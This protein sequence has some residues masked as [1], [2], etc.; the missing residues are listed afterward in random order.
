MKKITKIIIGATLLFLIIGMASAT[1]Y[2]EIFKAS[3][4]LHAIGTNSFVDE[5]GHNIMIDEYSD[6][7]YATWFENDTEERYVVQKYNNTCY[8]GADDE[9]DYYIL[10]IVE[11]E[12]TKYIIVSWT[13]NGP[14]DAKIV[15]ENLEEFNL[16]N[17]LDPIEV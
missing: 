14:D 3:S 10:E 16:I 7:V 12:G 17:N 15:K 11:K 8:I 6:E 5:Q 2:V 4:S 9:N 13:P 1:D